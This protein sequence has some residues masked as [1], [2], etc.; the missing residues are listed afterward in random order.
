MSMHSVV[1]FDP[2][3]FNIILPQIGLPQEKYFKHAIQGDNCV[4][5]MQYRETTV[6]LPHDP[7]Y[8]TSSDWLAK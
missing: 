5:E 2:M 4:W 8:Y 1:L 6:F 7:K 3:I